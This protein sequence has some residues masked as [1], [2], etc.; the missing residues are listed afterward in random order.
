MNLTETNRGMFKQ[1]LSIA[2]TTATASYSYDPT[3]NNSIL[4]DRTFDRQLLVQPPLS[5]V[6]CARV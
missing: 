3:D 4:R 6:A 1:L 5:N 2:N